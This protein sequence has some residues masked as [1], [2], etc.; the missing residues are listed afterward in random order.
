MTTYRD[1]ITNAA[2]KAKL[3]SISQ[4]L[5]A[6]LLQTGKILLKE[7]ISQYSNENFL[8]FA[9]KN[10][11]IELN[12][13]RAIL[14]WWT[15]KKEYRE[16]INFFTVY[17]SNDLPLETAEL[18]NA[19]AYN[20]NDPLAAMICVQVGP[21]SY[22]WRTIRYSNI[23]NTIANMDCF[24][25]YPDVLVKD[26]EKVTRCYAVL[27]KECVE[28]KFVSFEDYNMFTTGSQVY[29][30]IERSNVTTEVMTKC[31]QKKYRI[32]YNERFEMDDIDAPLTIPDK[33][34]TLFTTALT[35]DFAREYPRLSD[36]TYTML[37]ERLDEMEHSIQTS[38]TVS[39]FIG[40]YNT[41]DL[42][43][44]YTAGLNGT[45]LL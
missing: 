37:K 20:P 31:S 30:A 41:S 42:S 23:Q 9:R 11:D 36:N 17:S 24:E 16:G 38:S 33:W 27:S 18:L 13:G 19:R 39:K 26:L 1:I 15:L 25:T 32:V 10:I 29:T 28:M 43:I 5:P 34:V 3:C 6:N 22:S 14:G 4:Q 45:F 12:D 8:E 2:S 7:R 35:V 21:D 40:R 44:G